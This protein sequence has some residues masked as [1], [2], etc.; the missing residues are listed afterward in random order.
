MTIKKTIAVSLASLALAQAGWALRCD[1]SPLESLAAYTAL[2]AKTD[3]AAAK[4]KTAAESIKAY[5]PELKAACEA[6]NAAN[7]A[8]M[9]H[10]TQEPGAD[11]SHA[12]W[13]NTRSPQ[14]TLAYKQWDTDQYAKE[15]DRKTKFDALQ[16]TFTKLG[17]MYCCFQVPSETLRDAVEVLTSLQEPNNATAVEFER[18]VNSVINP[19][20]GVDDFAKNHLKSAG[21][22][23]GLLANCLLASKDAKNAKYA[24]Y[25][26]SDKCPVGAAIYTANILNGRNGDGTAIVNNRNNPTQAGTTNVTRTGGRNGV[27]ALTGESR[28]VTTARGN[29]ATGNATPTTN[30]TNSAGTTGNTTRSAAQVYTVKAN[31]NLTKIARELAPSLGNPSIADLVRALYANMTTR[32]RNNPSLIFAGDTINLANVKKDLAA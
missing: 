17:N 32:S 20:S 11:V 8:S 27:G 3:A 22:N 31:D 16:A 23:T 6:Y 28:N 15:L 2:H 18:V 7:Q 19:P 30:V 10:R 14:N 29:G 5:F 9:D 4:L 26:Y 24:E 1:Q 12:L 13:W 21:G 25:D